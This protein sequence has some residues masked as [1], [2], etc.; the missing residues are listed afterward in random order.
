MIDMLALAVRD[1]ATGRLFQGFTCAIGQG[2]QWV[3][4][5]PA[6]KVFEAR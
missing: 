6:T 2:H 5:T 1:D 4:L 3:R